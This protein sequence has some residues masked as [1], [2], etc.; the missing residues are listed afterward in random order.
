[1]NELPPIRQSVIV[2]LEIG[3][4]FDL[5]TRRM[6]EWWPLGAR[7]VSLAD[8]ISC[9]VEPHTGGRIYE[10]TRDGREE[11]W[12]RVLIW[13]PPTRLAFT[14]HPGRPESA[15]TEVEVSFAALGSGTKVD[16][17]HRRWERLGEH[18]AFV[19]GRFE[20]G[21]PGI[22]ARFSEC[23]SGA[24]E[25]SPVVGP[26]CLEADSGVSVEGQRDAERGVRP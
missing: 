2:P 9:H 11:I 19:R 13:N 18:A 5:F 7:S 22:L 12:G 16:L 20:S 21:W 23:A 17:K 14:W 1:M 4:A 6:T 3:E 26:G 8:A 25:L 24:P 10:R 15:P